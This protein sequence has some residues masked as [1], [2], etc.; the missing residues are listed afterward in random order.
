[1][2]DERVKAAVGPFIF[3]DHEM[4][5]ATC[6]REETDDQDSFG[7]AGKIAVEH[8]TATVLSEDDPDAVAEGY[9]EAGFTQLPRDALQEDDQVRLRLDRLDPS[10]PFVWEN[11]VEV[12]VGGRSLVGSQRDLLAKKVAS[13]KKELSDDGLDPGRRETAARMIQEL[14]TGLLTRIRIEMKRRC[15]KMGPML[16]TGG[17]LGKLIPLSRMSQLVYTVIPQDPEDREEDDGEAMY[18]TI[19]G[20]SETEA[21]FMFSGGILGQRTITDLESGVAHHAWFQNREN[22][23]SAD[24]APWVSRRVY[25][26]LTDLG[27]SE[28]VIR[29][30]REQEPIAVKKVGEEEV[31]LRVLDEDRTFPALVAETENDDR[32]WILMDEESPLVLRMHEAEAELL[33]SIDEVRVLLVV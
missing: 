4:K 31:E 30:G 11:E 28:I 32:L 21:A 7:N 29:W 12:G 26:E 23:V 25:R 17:V 16:E 3:V 24:T 6:D 5:D 20:V 9:L 18:L 10:N 33:R 2:A 8:F 15:F 1:M 22:V 19:L 13:L 14:N 27:T